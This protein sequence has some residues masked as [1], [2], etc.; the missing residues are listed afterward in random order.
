M[1]FPTQEYWSGVPYPYSGNLSNP[2]IEPRSLALR[3][4]L[5]QL[6]HQGSPYMCLKAPITFYIFEKK[7]KIQKNKHNII[8]FFSF[9]AKQI[10]EGDEREE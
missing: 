4:S 10:I 3:Q 9:Y 1:G 2:G 8:P 7:N 6:S 5:Y